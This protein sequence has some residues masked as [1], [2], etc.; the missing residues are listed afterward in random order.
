MVQL[1]IDFRKFVGGDLVLRKAMLE[2]R[3]QLSELSWQ[4]E[5]LIHGNSYIGQGN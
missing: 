1:K 3:I 2:E 5:R 4:L